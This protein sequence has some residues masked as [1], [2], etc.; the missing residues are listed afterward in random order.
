MYH[1]HSALQGLDDGPRMLYRSAHIYFLLV[2]ISN[3][4]VGVYLEPKSLRPPK[5][6]QFIIS[7]LL[8]LAPAFIL[9]GF[10]IEPQL[11]ELSRPYNKAGLFALF[12]VAILVII[13]ELV[14]KWRKTSPQ[15]K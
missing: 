2:S 6:L 13:A 15:Q 12:A 3:L 8:L 1:V 14:Y 10:F 9:A 4:L 11:D 5:W 7:A